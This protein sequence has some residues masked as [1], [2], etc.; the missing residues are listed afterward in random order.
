VDRAGAKKWLVENGLVDPKTGEALSIDNIKTY[1]YVKTATDVNKA[2]EK[3]LSKE[4]LDWIKRYPRAAKKT[5]EQQ[6]YKSRDE[7]F[8]VQIKN[9]LKTLRQDLQGQDG[10]LTVKY[11]NRM[12]MDVIADDVEGEVRDG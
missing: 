3:K 4:A 8:K 6:Y 1:D 5:V 9:T 12:F 10:N 11:V 7:K 2:D